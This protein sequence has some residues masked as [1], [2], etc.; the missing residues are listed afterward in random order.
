M[1]L[2]FLKSYAK[3]VSLD[4]PQYTQRFP[5]N[6]DKADFLLF[7]NQVICE[8]KDKRRADMPRQ[9][10]RVWEKGNLSNMSRA[11]SVDRS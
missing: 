4:L 10:E 11:T 7:G 6:K 3:A 5:Q 8:I 9:V 2:E 1:M